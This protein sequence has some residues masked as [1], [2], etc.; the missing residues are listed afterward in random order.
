[1]PRESIF[2]KIVLASQ[3]PYRRALLERLKVSFSTC[4]PDFKEDSLKDKNLPV[5][6][7]CRALALEKA[8]SVQHM[9]KQEVIIGSDQIAVFNNEF[10][11]KPGSPKNAINQLKKLSGSM[12]K[13][14]TSL[15][16]LHNGNIYEH[17]NITELHMRPLS[18]QQILSYVQKD[19]PIDCAGSYKLE[20]AGI[21]LFNAINTTDSSAIVGL[22][23]I[24]LTSILLK[25]DPKFLD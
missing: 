14:Y 25:I 22:P 6:K 7:L 4:A 17:V 8:K 5:E 15:C 19:N 24:E 1:M 3:S 21:A 23:M 9:F 12:H 18:D 13:L 20:K 16:V 2:M 11:N 10:L